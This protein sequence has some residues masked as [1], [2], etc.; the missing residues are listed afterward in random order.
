LLAV[1]GCSLPLVASASGG[2]A[3][4]RSQAL[5]L[6]GEAIDLF[7]AGDY[8]TAL[9]KFARADVLIPAPTLKLRMARCLDRLD[10]MHEAADQ[11][12]KIIGS[13]I[14]SWAPRKHRQA[15]QDAVGELATLLKQLPRILI[16]VAGPGGSSANVRIDSRPAP[17]G[18]RDRTID[19]GFHVF[20]ASVGLREA[21]RTMD[22]QRG[23]AVRIELILPEIA[24][25]TPPTASSSPSALSVAGYS[26]L[27]VAAAGIIVG[28]I[29]GGMLL[30]S[31]SALDARCPDRA[32]PREAHEDA[33]HFNT[34]RTIST[35][36]FIV[37]GVGL[38]A[39]L[40]LR[41]VAPDGAFS[42]K[43]KP[44]AAHR[45]NL[46]LR[47]SPAKLDIVGTF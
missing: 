17:A 29:T 6:A 19:P 8:A 35:V 14:K 42:G 28:G 45:P 11:Y 38:A 4:R 9:K 10:R 32:C 36:G 5:S 30:S 21:K 25:G 26:S 46:Q 16:E 22:L 44:W 18:T 23:A 47:L 7:D 39:G 34:L 2:Q 37:G 41:W 20:S 27:G 40:S 3:S 13:E 24:S 12:R 15:R 1:L 43:D 31:R 33:S